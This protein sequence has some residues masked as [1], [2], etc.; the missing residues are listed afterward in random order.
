[1]RRRHLSLKFLLDERV[2]VSAGKALETARHEVIYFDASGIAKGSTDSMVC[3]IALLNDAILVAQ[4]ADMKT[5]ARGHGV[6]PARFKSLNL[7]KLFCRESA[8]AG[9]LKE[10]MSLIEHE[11]ARGEGQERRFF[12]AIGDGVMRTHR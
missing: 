3:I 8:A 12:V 6:K 7:L 2:T 4:D 5:L 10:G 9:R 11:W 1:L